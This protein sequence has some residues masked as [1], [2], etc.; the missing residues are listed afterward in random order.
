MIE[1]ADGVSVRTVIFCEDV[2]QEAG[3]KWSIL[4]VFSA[5]IIIGVVP[6]AIRLALYIESEVSRPYKGALG[7][8]LRLE[9]EEIFAATGQLHA[10]VGIVVMPIP[11]MAVNLPRVGKLHI[12]M[13]VSPDKWVEIGSKEIRIGTIKNGELIPPTASGLPS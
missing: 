8:R 13:G 2:R 3:N 7:Y 11:Q 1:V 9:S 12:D 6:A 10:E 4:G 5:D